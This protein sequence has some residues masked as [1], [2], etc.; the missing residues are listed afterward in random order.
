MRVVMNGNKEIIVVSPDH[1]K[2][3]ARKVSHEISK[4][5]GFNAA[6]WNIKQFEDNE[7]QLGGNR[8]AIFIGN[9]EE[10]SL[11]NDFVQ[12]IKNIT[13]E[14]GACYGFDGTKAVIFGEGNLDQIKEFNEVLKKSAIIAAG[15]SGL[16]TLGAGIAGASIVLL[17]TLF[18]TG[19]SL[20]L[21]QYFQRKKKM[22]ELRTEQTKA[23]LTLFLA[24]NFDTWVGINK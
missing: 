22:K 11:T 21:Y 18:V 6:Y 23:A 5:P 16:A 1:Y 20:I 13:N 3:L 8:Y 19:P 12:V 4:M 7:F 24:N 15:K 17:P 10:N 9:S 2:D 14:G